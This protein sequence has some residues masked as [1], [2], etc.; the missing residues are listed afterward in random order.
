MDGYLLDTN[1]VK[2]WH[3]TRC[4]EHGLVAARVEQLDERA[5]L[6]VSVITLGEIEFGHR[7]ESPITTESQR[8]FSS[9][10]SERLPDRLKVDRHSVSHYGDLRARLFEK[11]A[12]IGKRAKVKRPEQLIDPVTAK[13]LGIQEN[14]LWI[15][16]QAL[17]RNLVLVTHDKMDHIRKV[18][19]ELRIED[20]AEVHS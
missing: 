8:E 20:W 17:E 4:P 12:P 6:Y 14:D 2:Y 3:D 7:A 16:A 9:F 19:S 5:P 13:T 11:Y 1:I 15:A 18:A 10:V